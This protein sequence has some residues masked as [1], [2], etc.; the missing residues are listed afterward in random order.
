[1]RRPMTMHFG[2]NEILLSLDVQFQ[3]QLQASKIVKVI[4]ELEMQIH[5]KYPTISQIFIEVEG[6]KSDLKRS[7]SK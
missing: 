3:P 6:L 7:E 4:D 2:P 5:E 1:M